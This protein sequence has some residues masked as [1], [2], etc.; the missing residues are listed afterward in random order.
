MADLELTQAQL[1]ALLGLSARRVRTLTSQGTLP[2]LADGRYGAAAVQAYI[3]FARADAVREAGLRQP[4]GF[5]LARAERMRALAKIAALEAA[6]RAGELIPLEVHERR[7]G[8]FVQRVRSA[9]A[10]LPARWA[11]HVQGIDS[12]AEAQL[13]LRPLTTE[14]LNELAAAPPAERAS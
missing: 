1:A 4:G 6:E 2:R 13:R 3:E 5:E 12:L 9:T 8:A 10:G 14:I 11:P 7:F